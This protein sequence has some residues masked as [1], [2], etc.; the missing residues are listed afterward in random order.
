MIPTEIL[1]IIYSKLSYS[2]IKNI[3]G[4]DTLWMLLINLRYPNVLRACGDINIPHSWYKSV[5]KYILEYVEINERSGIKRIDGDSDDFAEI[6][7]L[8]NMLS[9]SKINGSILLLYVY[10]N[11]NV[12]YMNISKIDIPKN[13]I[14]RICK[15]ILHHQKHFYSNNVR[16]FRS[17]DSS[18]YYINHG[19]FIEFE[20]LS[21]L[22]I[23]YLDKRWPYMTFMLLYG[24]TLPIDTTIA[25]NFVTMVF[26]LYR[27][28]AKKSKNSNYKIM[29]ISYLNK[30]KTVYDSMYELIR[31]NRV[32][33]P[34][35]W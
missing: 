7:R 28:K 15:N 23:V 14:I 6:I 34:S 12:V 19:D 35:D 21:E 29:A 33:N 2:E 31:N 3:S 17:E 24:V 27:S 25:K 4:N 1:A 26:E 22:M 9:G 30:L 13:Y 11:Y 20:Y 32:L 8:Y 10:L 5:Y 18:D 16:R